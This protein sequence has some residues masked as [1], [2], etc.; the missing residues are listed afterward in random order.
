MPSSDLVLPSS[1]CPAFPASAIS[2]RTFPPGRAVARILKLP[3]I[4][5][6]GLE[7]PLVSL[8]A[9]AGPG[10]ADR[11]GLGMIHP[12]LVD[13]FKI[14]LT[15][16]SLGLPSLAATTGRAAAPFVASSPRIL[17]ATSIHQVCPPLLFP[18]AARDV[19]SLALTKLFVFGSDPV[20]LY[21]LLTSISF[22][23]I[24]WV[25]KCTPMS[26]AGPFTNQSIIP[27]FFFFSG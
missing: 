15:L 8:P 26:D 1:A 17:P 20:T 19:P 11:S 3:A 6:R 21:Y 10:R 22:A 23:K 13:R 16:S 25:Y 12:D 24:Y 7:F 9:A 4:G 27:F 5:A 18:S 14:S 2:Q